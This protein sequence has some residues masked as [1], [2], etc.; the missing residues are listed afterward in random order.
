MRHLTIILTLLVLCSLA[1]LA[2]AKG[3]P[4]PFRDNAFGDQPRL[5]KGEDLVSFIKETIDPGSWEG[6][7]TIS[8][9]GG[10]LVVVHYERVQKQIELLLEALRI[11]G[12][13]LR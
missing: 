10:Y 9:R 5:S 6:S 11:S 7:K 8:Y 13:P 2:S 4:D 12:T 3:F 1:A